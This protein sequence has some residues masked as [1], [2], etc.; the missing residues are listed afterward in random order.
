[1]NDLLRPRLLNNKIQVFNI[2]HSGQNTDREISKKNRAKKRAI[3]IA[4]HIKKTTA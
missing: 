3:L 2:I 4:Q 1:V